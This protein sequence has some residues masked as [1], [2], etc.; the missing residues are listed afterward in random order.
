MARRK[1]RRSAVGRVKRRR[2]R[3]TVYASNPVRRRR[4]RSVR[5]NPVAR[6]R[7]RRGARRRNPVGIS[8]RGFLGNVVQGAKD[9]TAVVVGR[10]VTNLVAQRIPFGQTS[11]IGQ[12]A[13]RIII[14]TLLA[15]LV[16]KLTKSPRTAS[17][18]LAGAY[19]D[20]VAKALAPIPVI[21][22][23]VTG[24]GL[25]GRGVG[26]YPRAGV[27]VYPRLN[28]WAAAPN[29]GPLQITRQASNAGLDNG[30]AAAGN[31]HLAAFVR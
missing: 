12:A 22:P 17:F 24:L 28:G 1:R 15:P 30:M 18:F 26:V 21:G 23:A 3:R 11:A 9:A 20:V 27:G 7:R 14:G 25:Y 19:S 6:K 5:R 31:A 2:R 16:G 10:G 8:A 29:G 4:R 13:V